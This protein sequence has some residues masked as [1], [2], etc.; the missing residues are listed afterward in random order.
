MP[1]LPSTGLR[2]EVSA[3]VRAEM[4]QYLL[5]TLHDRVDHAEV[6]AAGR[7][8]FRDI[9]MKCVG[10]YFGNRRAQ[11]DHLADR[12]HRFL[13]VQWRERHPEMSAREFLNRVHVPQPETEAEFQKAVDDS[14][15][16]EIGSDE[17]V[18]QTMYEGSARTR[19]GD[20]LGVKIR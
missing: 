8:T 5:D 1:A 20:N 3:T 12:I 6:V 17:R 18:M 11:C 2:A 10:A 7:F 19:K 15:E 14:W 9:V 13:E 4:R 16:L